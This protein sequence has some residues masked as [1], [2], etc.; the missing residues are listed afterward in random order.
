MIDTSEDQLSP[1]VS[2]INSGLLGVYRLDFL[3]RERHRHARAAQYS[4][5]NE[6]LDSIWCELVGDATP[7]QEDDF[8]ELDNAVASSMGKKNEQ[9]GFSKLSK[10]DKKAFISQKKALMEKER[11]LKKLE[12]KQRKGTAYDEE[13]DDF[14]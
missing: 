12:N 10:E 6:D 7:P 9:K 4:K 1:K 5:W 11:F 8:K 13:D 3:W 2:K 14:D